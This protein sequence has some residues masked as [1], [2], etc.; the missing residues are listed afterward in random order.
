VVRPDV[1]GWRALAGLLLFF[2]GPV[3]AETL[4]IAVISDLNAGYGSTDY[5]PDVTGAVAAIIARHPDLVISTG[6]MV[7]GQRDTPKLTTPELTRMWD[8]FHA[9]VSDPLTQAGIPFL[10]TPGNHDASAYPG[11]EAERKAF[12]EAWAD[13]K[14]DVTM[15]DDAN[16]P[17]RMAASVGGVLFVG[18]DATR[19]GPMANDDMTWLGGILASK[20]KD[21]RRVVLFGHLPLMPIT[22][23]RQS[24]VIADPALFDLARSAGVNVWLS[25][26]HH[27][28]YS[29]TAGGILFVAQACLGTGLRKL[30]GTTKVA[31]RA[32]TWIEINDAGDISVSASSAPGYD[33]EIQPEDLPATLGQGP[34]ALHR[35]MTL[36]H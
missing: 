34:M 21:H 31:P 28:F 20:V 11:F 2:S 25:G 26:H 36:T 6:D 16:W 13:R 33:A 24:N 18:M 32:Y 3:Q 5:G 17:F 7:A 10:V 15:L 19:S 8:A 29:G 23:G 1:T 27:G 30:V 35:S 9:A 22:E 12:A 4:R 14:P